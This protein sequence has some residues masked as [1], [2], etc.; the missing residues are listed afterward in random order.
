TLHEGTKVFVLETLGKWKKIQ[1][2]DGTEGWIESPAI[3]EV[4]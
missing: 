3:R 2:T 1:L 4:K